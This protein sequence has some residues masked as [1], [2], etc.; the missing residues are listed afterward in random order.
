[1]KEQ[2]EV[3]ARLR[4]VSGEKVFGPGMAQLLSGVERLGSLR[5]SA[6]EMKMSY[7]KAWTVLRRCE[8]QLGFPLMERH[9]GGPGGGGAKLTPQGKALMEGYL[10]FQAEAQGILEEL[11]E[12]HLGDVL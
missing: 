7:N 11:L 2:F 1:M 8:E 12:K 5:R 10:A 9:I 4:L 3:Q 6:A